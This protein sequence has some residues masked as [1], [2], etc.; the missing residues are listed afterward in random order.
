MLRRLSGL[1]V[2]CVLL[3]CLLTGCE[4]ANRGSATEL[5]AD[6]EGKLIQTI[7]EPADQT[8]DMDALEQYIK[9]KIDAADSSDGTSAAAAEGSSASSS[10]KS[11]SQ[12]GI[13]LDSCKVKDGK[14]QIRLN[15]AGYEQYT[16]FNETACF[17]GTIREAQNAGYSFDRTFLDEKG[18]A[19]DD[20][21]A[22]I[23]ERADEWKVLIVE[24]PM[25]LRVPDKILYTSENLKASGRTTAVVKEKGDSTA[26]TGS[27]EKETASASSS[28]EPDQKEASETSDTGNIRMEQ[29]VI[30]DFALYY[31]IY[32]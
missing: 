1:A 5:Q 13:Q 29:F 11:S 28:A 31:V 18:K 19:A 32:K 15:Y 25:R 21:A 6:E 20:A 8:I 22:S 26:D 4:F 16:A 27:G 14:L 23:T 10:A 2:I 17:C 24:E 3:G 30:D 7:V 12:D 9:D